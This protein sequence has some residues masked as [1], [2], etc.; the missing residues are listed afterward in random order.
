MA[1]ETITYPKIYFF[2]FYLAIFDLLWSLLVIL[3]EAGG[4]GSKMKVDCASKVQV[5][6]NDCNFG[7]GGV[8]YQIMSLLQHFLEFSR[9]HQ[10]IS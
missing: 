5:K 1:P 3:G 2:T 10:E 6:T 7:C 9:T 4:S 8:Y